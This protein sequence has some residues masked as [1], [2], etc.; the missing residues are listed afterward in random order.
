MV[1]RLWHEV[2]H[3]KY[4]KNKIVIEWFREGRKK[5]YRISNCWRALTTSLPIIT[6]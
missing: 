4:L 2:V 3:K 6:D 1:P 5:L